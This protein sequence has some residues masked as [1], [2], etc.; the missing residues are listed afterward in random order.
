VPVLV[1]GVLLVVGTDPAELGS[2]IPHCGELV[3]MNV[4]LAVSHE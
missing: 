1:G 2:E 3:V 4:F